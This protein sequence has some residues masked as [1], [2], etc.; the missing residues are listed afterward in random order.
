MHTKAGATGT[1]SGIKRIK[2]MF[3]H[4]QPHAMPFVLIKNNNIIIG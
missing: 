2:D 1:I 3:K 4:L